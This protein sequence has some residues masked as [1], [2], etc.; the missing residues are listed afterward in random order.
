MSR[1]TSTG[2][3]GDDDSF[4]G[5]MSGDGNLVS[6]MS[7]A[8]DLTED[9][10]TFPTLSTQIYVRDMTTGSVQMITRAPDGRAGES[11]SDAPKLSRTG[12]FI[13]FESASDNLVA[14]D[15][16]DEQDIL[17]ANTETGEIELISLGWDGSLADD[18]SFTAD[19]SGNG[20]FV[21]YS[22]NAENLVADP[23]SS[24]PDVFLFDTSYDVTY[25]L[26]HGHDGGPA[27]GEFPG[28]YAG[29]IGGSSRYVAFYS[30]ATNLTPNDDDGEPDVFCTG[31]SGWVRTRHPDEC[32]ARSSRRRDVRSECD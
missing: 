30:N 16:N 6:F 11:W 21:S 1:S 18:W 8:D 28:S 5:G 2:G 22:S 17:R 31:S 10:A 19:V 23:T 27:E 24:G 20:R 32:Q 12:K 9:G 7:F 13:V 14:G 15:T 3:P 29:D 4:P 26:S 25:L